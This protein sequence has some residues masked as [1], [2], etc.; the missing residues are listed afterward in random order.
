[1]SKFKVGELFAGVGGISQG[2]IRAG[3]DVGWANEIDKKACETYRANYN[4]RLIEADIHSINPKDLENIDVLSG[5]FPCQAFSVAGYRKGFDDARGNLFFEVMRLADHLQPKAIFLENVKNL[6]SH[7]KG[8]TFKVI[9][10]TLQDSGYYVKSAVL[11]TCKYSELPQNRE[12]IYI[13][14]FKNINSYYSFNFPGKTSKTINIEDI[15]DVEVANK[16]YYNKSKYYDQLKSEINKEY[17]IY[18]WRR[19]YLRENKSGVCP[20]L[21]ANMGTGGHNVPLVKDG[22][23]IRK[24][25]PREC[26]RLQGFP[27]NYVLPEY[28]SDTALYK[29]AGNSVS[30]PVIEQ[31]A[32]N[33][34]S[35]LRINDELIGSYIN[36]S[37][38]EFTSEQIDRLVAV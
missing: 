33:I 23:D 6:E 9:V 19:V 10:K 37:S 38:K 24:L 18:Q 8:N 16:Y 27:E 28:V 11:N 30:V 20:T 14:A 36:K 17:T 5:G 29:Q 15:L 34:K 25:T 4:H 1:M 31:I 3:F 22:K 12:R 32:Q 21:T 2:F 7:D 35:S 13:V 26:F